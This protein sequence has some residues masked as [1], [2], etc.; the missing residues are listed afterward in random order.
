MGAPVNSAGQQ[1]PHT[2]RIHPAGFDFTGHVHRLC[3]DMVDRL[4]P[5]R[6]IDVS[7]VAV[8]FSQTRKATAYGMHASLT[9]MRFAGGL[10]HATHDGRKWGVQRL[11]GPDG[12]EFLYI[13]NF[14]LPRFLDLPLPE[15]LATILHELW[16]ISESF[17]GDVRRFAG[18]CFLHGSSQHAYDARVRRLVDGWLAQQP[19]PSLYAFLHGTFRDLVARHG[20]VFGRKIPTPKLLPVQ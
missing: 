19:P 12:R 3:R 11:Y 2:T 16:H 20:R 6:H 8:A 15:K 4:D 13:L 18:R 10:R 9:P 5:L 17:D 1:T 7:R 14:Y